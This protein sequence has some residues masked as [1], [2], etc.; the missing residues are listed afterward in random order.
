METGMRVL[1][2][3]LL[4]SGVA[5]AQDNEQ[6]KKDI[7][8]KVEEIIKANQER[9]LKEI[10]AYLDKTLGTGGK[11]APTESAKKPKR[12]S[13]GPGFLGIQPG[14]P[15]EKG[16]VSVQGVSPG[17][18]ADGKLEESDVILKV[19]GTDVEDVQS[20][21]QA[22]ASAGAGNE[23]TLTV[24]RG[25]KKQEIKVVLGERPQQQQPPQQQE[26]EEQPKPQPT[27]KKEEPK[28]SASSKRPYLGIIIEEREKEGVVITDVREG[29]P[30]AK[31]GVQKG[32]VLVKINDK[33]AK[34]EES[35]REALAASKVG[36][37]LSLTVSREGKETT[38][39]V[40]LEERK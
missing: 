37:E 27:P 21:A 31:A 38:I 17:G 5:L 34:T 23:V 33:P 32:D 13:G 12:K 2:A 16:G 30:A 36:D 11:S 25:G 22:I 18:P 10:E 15:G 28:P 29:S 6:L 35:L 40:V 3:F 39:K 19:N 7:L 14:E 8:K 9:T 24:D 26:E 4:V 20:L 1:V